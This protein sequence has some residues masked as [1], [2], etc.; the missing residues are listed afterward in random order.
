MK[1]FYRNLLYVVLVCCCSFN[2]SA[3]IQGN[4]SSPANAPLLKKFNAYSTTIDEGD[5]NNYYTRNNRDFAKVLPINA[6][7]YRLDL[8]MGKPDCWASNMVNGTAQN[9]SYRWNEMDDFASKCNDNNIMPYISWCYIPTPFQQG[10]NWRD[11]NEN[12]P[13]WENLW[14]DMHADLAAHMKSV[15]KVPMYNEIYNEPDLGEFFWDVLNQ[16]NADVAFLQKDDFNQ[17]Y[18]QM[19]KAGATGVRR[20]N[21]DA[22]VGGPA[23]AVAEIYAGGFLDYVKSN[24]LPL[25]FFSMHQYRDSG[26]WPGRVNSVRDGLQSRG[27]DQVPLHISE[28]NYEELTWA[29]DNFYGH[30]YKGA[31]KAM[32]YIKEMM[33]NFQDIEKIHWAQFL[34][35][36]RTGMGL[37]DYD[38]H[39]KAIYNAFKIFGDMPVQRYDLQGL[40]ADLQGMASGD[41]NKFTICIWNNNTGS[42]KN[43]NIKFSS[44]PFATGDVKMYRID[45]THASVKDGAP[46]DLATDFVQNSVSANGYQWNGTIPA[47]GIVYITLVKSG[48]GIRDFHPEDDFQKTATFIKPHFYYYARYKSFWNHFDEKRWISYVGS[49]NESGGMVAPVAIE[50]ENLPAVISFTGSITGSPQNTGGN[51]LV[52]IQIDFRTGGNY[53]KSVLFHG[54]IYNAGRNWALPWGKGGTANQVQQVDLTNFSVT[55]AQYAP[56]GW[57][58]RV[59]ITTM[60][61]DCGANVS[62]TSQIKSGQ[63]VAQTPYTGTPYPIPGIIEAENFDNGGEGVSYHD[64]EPANLGGAYRTTE[65]V[66][67]E[68]CSEGGYDLGWTVAGEWQEYSVNVLA[69]GTYKVGTRL[70]GGTSTPGSFHIEFDGVN[71]SGTIN[72]IPTGGWQTWATV[73][74]TFNLTS[75]THIMRVY[76]EKP[77]VNVNSFTFTNLS[78]IG[79]GDGLTGNYFNGMNFETPVFNRKDAVIQFDWNTGSPDASVN[80]DQFSIRWTGQIQAKYS[81]TY[82]FYVN[83]DNGRR[84]W[85]NGQLIIDKW[86]PDYGV[87][88]TGTIDL[89]AGVKYDIRLE[90]FEKDG[91]ANC[92]LE[93]SSPTQAREVVATSQLYANKLPVVTLTAPVNNATYTTPA[94]ITIT[95]N[96]SDVDGTISNVEFYNGATLLGTSNT[97]PYTYSWT[98]VAIGAYP[99]TARAYDNEAAVIISSI[100]TIQVNAPANQ[101]PVV[102]LTA[103]VNN[104]T[105]TAPASVT[106]T[107]NASDVDGNINKVEFYNGTTLLVTNATAPYTYSWTNVTAGSYTI[108]AK[109]YDNVNAITTSN[110]I[111]IQVNAPANQLPI[112]TLTA[113]ANNATYIAPANVMITANANDADGSI[114]KVEFYNGTTLL[115]TDATA[116]YTY[117]WTNVTA[118]SYMITAKAYDNVTAVTTSAAVTIQVNAAANQLPTV[119]ITAPNNN[120]TYTAPASVAIT[121]NASD[122]DGTISKV[123][124]YTGSTLLGTDAATPFTYSWTNVTAGNY[125]ITAKAYDNINAVTTSTAISIQ[126]NALVNQLPTVSITSPANNAT[127]TAPVN[128]IITADAS[129]TDGTINKVEFYNGT[130]L[131]GTNATAPYTYSWTNVTAGSY[132]ITAKAY[133]NTNSATTSSAITIQVNAPVNQPPVVHVTVSSNNAVAPANIVITANATDNGVINKVEFYNGTTLLSTVTNAPYT[134][135]WTNVGTGTYSI[136]AK[137]YDNAN[138]STTSDAVVVSVDSKVPTSLT[139]ASNS[140]NIITAPTPFQSDTKI[141]IDGSERIQSVV[142]YNTCGIEVERL[143]G[144]DSNELIIGENLADGMYLLQVVTSAGMTTIKVIKAK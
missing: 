10:G 64:N 130:T 90:Y 120:A 31:S 87:E 136:T 3:Q 39:K 28:Y 135:T 95:A 16:Q 133:D 45:K 51:S 54:G 19:Y 107:A 92:K 4:F 141:R 50:T 144:I 131:L 74:D 114:N 105:Y 112:V 100:V 47:Q 22:I 42:D 57:D 53:T 9:R 125:S 66:D 6:P 89:K 37:I 97:A 75:G 8:A 14:G 49:G 68:A 140:M 96:A 71:T 5:H 142:I 2:V 12:I 88:Y 17:R 56:V 13:N 77:D 138:A 33:D 143:V 134:Y 99:I 106:I 118:G 15:L 102:T 81:D 60:V 21:P 24:N 122:P 117:S 63:T 55:L 40:D 124:F 38:G 58:G 94:N 121:A 116:P 76:Y 48:S 128:I 109:A 86:I 30:Y 20:G 85:V 139:S 93:W 59:L 23:L 104:A 132:T 36:L 43:A 79:T 110:A 123:E 101:L 108:T 91:G 111:T 78:S 137:V 115:A 11:L 25:D 32:V 67:I 127:Y 44:I 46:E 69:T 129:D 27:F 126:V 65:G 41:G 61:Q 113:P 52:G 83:S 29:N 72:G 34:N 103:P 18:N 70:S 73:N 82:T 35:P 1:L 62:F 119:S 7:T 84:L 80:V 26:P 98:G